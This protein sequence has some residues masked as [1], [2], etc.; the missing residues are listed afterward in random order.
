MVRSEHRRWVIL[1]LG[2]ALMA[3]A[4]VGASAQT[5]ADV[6]EARRN[7]EIAEA[8]E[9]QAYKDYVA[10]QTRLDE[11]VQ[12]YELLHAEHE[13]LQYRIERMEA[14]VERYSTRVDELEESARRILVDAYTNGQ[15]NL[16]GSAFAARSIQELVTSSA[17]MDRAAERELA[18]L[19]NLEAV[20]READ[21]SSAELDIRRADVAANEDAA[22][23]I[24]EEMAA[25][26]AEKADIL[27]RASAKVRAAIDEGKLRSSV[28][29]SSSSGGPAA[30]SAV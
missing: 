11:A 13:E 9:D 25:L 30:A 15:Q 21:R 3:L 29:R 27:A 17:V 4:P 23:V 2:I 14:A 5:Q 12:E 20:S 24:V 16:V 6:D 18:S 28:M 1:L 22:A 10:V 26:H 19:D 7:K 8:R